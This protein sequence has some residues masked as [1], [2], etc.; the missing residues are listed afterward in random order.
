MLS[1]FYIPEVLE[2]AEAVEKLDDRLLVLRF[3]LGKLEAAL[4]RAFAPVAATV[5]PWLNTAVQALTDFVNGAGQVIA[6]LFGGV[7]VEAAKT[8]R[9]TGRA[10]KRALADFDQ[11]DRLSFGGG[12]GSSSYTVPA[13]LKA[14]PAQYRAIADQIKKILEPLGA[15]DFSAACAAF[16]RLKAAI[17]PL[18]RGLFAGLEWAWFNL[19]TPMAAWGAEQALPVF[20]DALAAGLGVLGAAINAARPVLSWLWE[21]LLKPMGQWAGQ[22]LLSALQ[23]LTG[24]LNNLAQWLGTLQPAMTVFTQKL[25]T[26]R[27][28]FL[29]LCGGLGLFQSRQGTVGVGLSTLSQLAQNLGLRLQTVASAVG[30]VSSHLK[31]MLTSLTPAFKTVANTAI[32]VIN[33]AL[34]GIEGAINAMVSVLN[35]LRIDIPKWVPVVGGKKFSMGLSY[36]DLPAVPYLAKGAVLPANKPFLAMVGDQRH[37]T[38]IEAPLATIQEAV[39]DVMGAGSAAQ[40]DT[41]RLLSQILTAIAAIEVGDDTIGRA[42]RRYESRMALMGGAL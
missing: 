20:L 2:A 6:A 1:E 8:V 14:I 3:N 32:G 16:G 37:G 21:N 12:G 24:H 38:N 36:V 29:D 13:Q 33:T 26:L 39:A 34:S 18:T 9:V 17:E 22:T 19:L 35:S 28:G 27:Q 41:N 42:A 15:I 11:L 23:A 40:L 7:Q 10:M 30:A 31:T 5:V 25:S 4:Q